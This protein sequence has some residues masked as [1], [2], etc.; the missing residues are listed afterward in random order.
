MIR[1]A[2]YGSTSAFPVS[3][4][5]LGFL[6]HPLQLSGFRYSRTEMRSYMKRTPSESESSRAR[7]TG[8]SLEKLI[9]TGLL[10]GRR[11]GHAGLQDRRLD[12]R[13]ADKAID[14]S[15]LAP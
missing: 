9:I 1:T 12:M 3:G 15:R 7:L 6:D 4:M 2:S 14:P 10:L 11:S 13:R 8:K 5:P